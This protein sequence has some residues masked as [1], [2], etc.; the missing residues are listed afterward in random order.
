VIYGKLVLVS[1]SCFAVAGNVFRTIHMRC[2]TCDSLITHNTGV[3][4]QCETPFVPRRVRLD[5]SDKDFFLKADEDELDL[6]DDTSNQVDGDLPPD[7]KST[8]RPFLER[9]DHA[10]NDTRL[11]GG[12]IRRACAFVID[13]AIIFLLGFFMFT[14]S[15]IGYKVGLSAHGKSVTMENATALY[16]IF[17]WAWVGLS[18]VYFVVFHGIDGK[19]IGKWFFGLR[20]VGAEDRAIIYR[21]AFLRWLAAV[22]FAPILLGF[23]WV[24]WSREKR[25]WHDIIAQTWVVRD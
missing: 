6:S 8:K 16:F 9:T 19:T 24:L 4:S 15:Y 11:W 23:L 12:F 25:A 14:F 10:E 3:C 5:W 18:A 17:T 7:R 20:V 13:C 22:G 2:P 1:F 21:Q